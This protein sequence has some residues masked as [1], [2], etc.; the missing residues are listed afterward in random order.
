MKKL[1]W[2]LFLLLLAPAAWAHTVALMWQPSSGASSYNVYRSTNINGPYT[3]IG[4]STST[5]Y[6]D[7][8]V[9]LGTTYFY[10][11]TAVSGTTESG[12]SNQVQAVIPPLQAPGSPT[13]LT[14]AGK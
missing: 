4:S 5:N 2:L 12:P 10:E 9:A 1:R 11:V 8:T 14:G 6:T 3:E 7:A 13:N